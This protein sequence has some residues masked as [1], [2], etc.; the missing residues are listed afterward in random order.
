MIVDINV[1]IFMDLNVPSSHRVTSGQ[2]ISVACCVHKLNPPPPP[3]NFSSQ[4]Q[5]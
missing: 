3:P 4:C 5:L 2:D 1:V